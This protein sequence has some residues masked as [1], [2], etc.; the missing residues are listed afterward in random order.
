MGRDLPPPHGEE[1][2]TPEHRVLR[3][4]TLDEQI[5][6]LKLKAQEPWQEIL[7]PLWREAGEAH[8]K[9]GISVTAGYVFIHR[10]HCTQA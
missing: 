3:N 7:F 10:D 4:P 1:S 2:A 9:Q 5:N 8:V 6:E